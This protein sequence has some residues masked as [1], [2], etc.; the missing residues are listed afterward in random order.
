MTR[1]QLC[2]GPPSTDGSSCSL[3]GSLHSLQEASHLEECY[4][5]GSSGLLILQ[6]LSAVFT[7]HMYLGMDG[8]NE[9]GQFQELSEAVE[10]LSS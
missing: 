6:Y 3:K 7:V 1:K 5:P 4:F 10:L 2:Q 8:L 9:S